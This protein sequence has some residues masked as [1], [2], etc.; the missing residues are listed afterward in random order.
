MVLFIK[1]NAVIGENLQANHQEPLHYEVELSFL[2]QQG[3]FTAV[4]VG[5]D[6]TKRGLQ[7]TLKAKGLPWER[8]KSFTGSALFSEFVAIKEITE[9]LTITLD[10]NGERRQQGNVSMM[11]FRPDN[12]LQE[13]QSFINLEDGD[14]VMTG[15]PAGVG[16][17]ISGDVFHGQ[18]LLGTSLLVSQT[19]HAQ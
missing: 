16:Q 12:I 18:V 15:T 2:Y 8:A 4:A 13:I 19:W 7:S 3:M 9:D 11:L 14:I 10:I 6:L 1:P 17:I 5:L